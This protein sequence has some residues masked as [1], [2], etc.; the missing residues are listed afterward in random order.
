MDSMAAPVNRQRSRAFARWVTGMSRRLPEGLPVPL[1]AALAA[2]VLVAILYTVASRDADEPR[3]WAELTI[4]PDFC[5]VEPLQQHNA[6][7]CEPAGG[8]V[9]RVTFSRPLTG[10][11]V[12]A[13]RGSCCPGT[14]AASIESDSTVLVVVGGRPLAG[15][16]RASLFVP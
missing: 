5:R 3:G 10:S 7:R 12:V 8:G 16:I 4:T 14:I 13:S 9:Y 2:V 11:T 1:V 6:S 15:P